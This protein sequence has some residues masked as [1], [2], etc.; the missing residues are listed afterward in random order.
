MMSEAYLPTLES[1]STEILRYFAP[2]LSRTAAASLIASS[3]PSNV[4]VLIPTTSP[5]I[6]L[7]ASFNSLSLDNSATQGL[8]PVN[9]KLTT[10]TALLENR[11]SSTELPSKFL[12]EKLLKGVISS[13]LSFWSVLSDPVLLFSISDICF[14][15]CLMVSISSLSVFSSS[16][17]K[18]SLFDS[19]M[20]AR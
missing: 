13:E 11:L 17:V 2:W 14:S 7:M 18:D 12:P 15:I 20:P 16:S 8:Q 3:F 9:Q 19:I 4:S 6:D 5:P 1:E 10:V